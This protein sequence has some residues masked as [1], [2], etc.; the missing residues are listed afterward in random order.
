MRPSVIKAKLARNEPVLLTMVH[1]TD[2]SVCE[3]TSL[4]GF[5]GIWMD[6]EHHMYSLETASIMM[7]AARVGTADVLARAAKPPSRRRS[8]RRPA[9]R[10]AASR[11]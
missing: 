2:P 3:L 6:L 4:M 8:R 10:A 7:R 9:W 5:D 11:R 1:F